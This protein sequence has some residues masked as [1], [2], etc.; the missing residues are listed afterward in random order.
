MI[1]D[2]DI[3]NMMTESLRMIYVNMQLVPIVDIAYSLQFLPILGDENKI[4]RYLSRLQD[5]IEMT[6]PVLLKQVYNQEAI[7]TILEVFK[8]LQFGSILFKEKAA[9][10]LLTMVE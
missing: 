6:N 8:G 3:L 5:T 4:T 10:I 9:K 1:T 7:L 2:V